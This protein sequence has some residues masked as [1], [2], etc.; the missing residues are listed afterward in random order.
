MLQCGWDEVS[1]LF[2]KAV[3]VVTV[4]FAL[5]LLMATTSPRTPARAPRPFRR[6]EGDA[7]KETSA[8]QNRPAK[9]SCKLGC[10]QNPTYRQSN[11][12]N[13]FSHTI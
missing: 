13:C 9:M 12:P 8:G 4:T 3:S 6:G 1:C 7:G 2:E 5:S 11:P 10:T